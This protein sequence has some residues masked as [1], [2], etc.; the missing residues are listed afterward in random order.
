MKNAWAEF[1]DRFV[2]EEAHERVSPWHAFGIFLIPF[3]CVWP[4]VKHGYTLRARVIAFGWFFIWSCVSLNF[5][6]GGFSVSIG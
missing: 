3:F 1:W 2:S 6:A 4:L 5:S